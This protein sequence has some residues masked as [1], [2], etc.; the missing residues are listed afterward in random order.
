MLKDVEIGNIQFKTFK[1][2]FSCLGNS[3]AREQQPRNVPR[4]QPGLRLCANRHLTQP[5]PAP[6]TLLFRS[7]RYPTWLHRALVLL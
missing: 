7:S 6:S 4:S 3:A 5:E 2:F 1:I